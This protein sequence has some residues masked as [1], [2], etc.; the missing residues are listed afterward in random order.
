M[1]PIKQILTRMKAFCRSNPLKAISTSMHGPVVFV[2]IFSSP[3]N[4]LRVSYCEQ[5][6]SGVRPSVSPSVREQLPKKSSPLKPA[7]RF[8]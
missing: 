8:Q 7:N 2:Y 3:D 4:V 5:S 6:M 1:C